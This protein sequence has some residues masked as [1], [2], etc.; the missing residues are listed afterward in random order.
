MENILHTLQRHLIEEDLLKRGPGEQMY[1][2]S[3][4]KF[5]LYIGKCSN[6]LQEIYNGHSR[7]FRLYSRLLITPEAEIQSVAWSTI[8]ETLKREKESRQRELLSGYAIRVV[9]DSTED[10]YKYNPK[11]QDAIFDFL[12]NSLMN[13]CVIDTFRDK[14]EICDLVLR[15]LHSHDA[16][17]NYSQRI[18]YLRLLGKCIATL[19]DRE[20]KVC[21]Y[22]Y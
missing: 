19:E 2:V 7:A 1:K 5:L 11:L 6:Y 21:S 8:F 22:F 18:N 17:S 3:A 4:I 16:S 15:K 9:A 10:L 12:Y 14:S 13:E 20:L